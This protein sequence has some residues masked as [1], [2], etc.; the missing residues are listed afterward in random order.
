MTV[1]FYF[2]RHLKPKLAMSGDIILRVGEIAE[3]F[4][5]I[6]R[7]KVEIIATD[8]HT[9][10]ATLEEGCYFGEIGLMISGKRTVTVKATTDCFFQVLEK[11]RFDMIMNLFPDQKKFLTKVT[12]YILNFS[13]FR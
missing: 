11:S 9:V 6:K 4:F 13:K 12:F 1:N 3:E 10:I 2:P 8:N 7:G 5:F